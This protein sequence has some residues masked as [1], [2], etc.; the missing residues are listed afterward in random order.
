MRGK[1]ELGKVVSSHSAAWGASSLIAKL[2]ID[3]PSASC[4]PGK[5]KA[6]RLAPKSGLTT[7]LWAVAI[8]QGSS[9]VVLDAAAGKLAQ[10]RSKVNSRTAYFE[11][12]VLCGANSVAGLP[13]TL[14]VPSIAG[15]TLTGRG[16]RKCSARTPW[17]VKVPAGAKGGPGMFG[18]GVPSTGS[19]ARVPIRAD[20]TSTHRL[21]VSIV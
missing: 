12:W 8:G 9:L 6:L 5:M 20:S 21:V 10:A 18:A 2:R 19:R 16:A 13:S 4:S 15:V 17:K 1:T 11:L 3:S 14:S 7:L